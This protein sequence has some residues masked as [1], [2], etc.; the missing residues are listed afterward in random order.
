MRALNARYRGID[1]PTDVLSFAQ[2]HDIIV[3]GMPKLLGDVVISVDTAHRQAAAAGRTLEDEL[4]Q[5]AIHGVL[6]LLGYDDATTEGYVEMV[7]KAE[8]IRRRLGDEAGDAESAPR[9]HQSDEQ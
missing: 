1:A 8:K 4:G 2:E 3:P 5:L 9:G 6:H 7:E